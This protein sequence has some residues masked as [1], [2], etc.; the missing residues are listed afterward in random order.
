MCSKKAARGARASTGAEP[1]HSGLASP[2][3]LGDSPQSKGGLQGMA[4]PKGWAAHRARAA[5]HT[6]P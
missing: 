5:Q 3:S 6:K 1:T 2:V 4:Q